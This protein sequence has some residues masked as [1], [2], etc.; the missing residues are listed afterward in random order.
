MSDEN[1]FVQYFMNESLSTSLTLFI[2]FCSTGKKKFCFHI[3]MKAQLIHTMQIDIRQ[4]FYFFFVCAILRYF[5]LAV[6][7]NICDL[8][9]VVD[10]LFAMSTISLMP[11]CMFIVFA[12]F[13]FLSCQIRD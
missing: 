5:L 6:I 4:N 11:L 8:I 1:V 12:F 7:L 9:V 2:H 13:L 3:K 10:A